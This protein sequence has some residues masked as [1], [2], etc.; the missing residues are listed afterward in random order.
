LVFHLRIS[1]CTLSGRKIPSIINVLEFILQYEKTDKAADNGAYM[2][3]SHTLCWSRKYAIWPVV[4]DWKLRIFIIDNQTSFDA[5]IE[6]SIL[7]WS[8]EKILL[9]NILLTERDQ[10]QKL[11]HNG[12]LLEDKVT[13]LYQGVRHTSVL[14]LDSPKKYQIATPDLDRV[15][16][17][18]LPS[19]LASEFSITVKHWNGILY[20]LNLDPFEYID[21]VK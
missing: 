16:L 20:S 21:D 12:I 1:I 10:Q 9:K 6:L 11:K 17:D 19:K 18:T 15:L 4:P 2:D 8:G 13:L 7:H 3:Q 5:F 14:T